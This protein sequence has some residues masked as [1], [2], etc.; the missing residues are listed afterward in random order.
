MA[1]LAAAG[2]PVADPVAA[3]D[4]RMLVD[5]GDARAA[6]GP[7]PD[8]A[9]RPAAGDGRDAERCLLA[10]LGRRWADRRRDLAGLE[11]PAA[12]RDFQWEVLRARAVIARRVWPRS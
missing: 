8:V 10:E 11:H 6:M 7:A 9:P 2:V 4:G 12:H 1:R 3:L 5:L